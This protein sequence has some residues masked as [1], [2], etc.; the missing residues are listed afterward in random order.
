ML[1]HINEF[2]G[3]CLI[4]GGG[5]CDLHQHGKPAYRNKISC[6]TLDV[7]EASEPDI[8]AD[9][10]DE[11]LLEALTGR[12]EFIYFERFPADDVGLTKGFQVAHKLLTESGVLLYHGGSQDLKTPVPELLTQAGFHFATKKQLHPLNSKAASDKGSY[13]LACK[14]R[15]LLTATDVNDLSETARQYIDD[16][17]FFDPAHFMDAPID[18]LVATFFSDRKMLPT[19]KVLSLPVEIDTPSRPDQMRC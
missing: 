16:Y 13:S 6:Y 9:I 18:Q 3:D 11:A 17:F 8:V 19:F 12:F 15:S 14:N 4:V 10:Q 7:K 5:W 2:S 1:R